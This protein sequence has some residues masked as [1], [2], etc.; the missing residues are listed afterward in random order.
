MQGASLWLALLLCLAPGSVYAATCSNPTGNEGDE[1]YNYNYH[2]PQFCN[3]TSWVNEGWIASPDIIAT[4]ETF[5]DTNIE[6]DGDYGNESYLEGSPV[7]LSSAGTLQSLSIYISSCNNCNSSEQAILAL[8]DATGSG[9]TPGNLL[10]TTTTFSVTQ[11]GWLTENVTTP[12]L[13]TA[14]TYW[15][16]SNNNDNDIGYQVNDINGTVPTDYC[17]YTFGAMPSNFTTGCGGA[18][19]IQVLDPYQYSAYGTLAGCGG[20]H[21]GDQIYNGAYHTYQ[22]CNGTLWEAME[23]VVSGGGGCSNPAG[24]EADEF[25]N[26]DY[27]TYQFCNG[28]NWVPFGGA[29]WQAAPTAS[30][31]YF[32]MSKGTYNGD[33]DGYASAGGNTDLAAADAICMSELTTNTGWKGY[34]EALA[35]GK[36]VSGNVHAWL[37]DYT[38]CNN[39]AANT[40]YYFAD[41]NNS[42]HGGNIFT[43][44]GGGDGPNSA[45][46]DWSQAS[47][48]GSGYSYWTGARNGYFEG[49]PRMGNRLKHRRRLHRDLEFRVER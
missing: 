5:G 21:E 30:T 34:A 37:C 45:P 11:T 10:A 39:L 32:V 19:N 38:T 24:R 29:S 42:T 1:I 41:A 9:G 31:G 17:N 3:G 35:D 16:M 12:V 28:T 44:I 8:Y 20:Y 33:I 22:F 23:L 6:V 15:L 47:Y 40:M 18:G 25:Y 49:S 2:V 26:K 14:G 46:V 7:T 48:F 36:L 43:T 4:G 13:L 27:H